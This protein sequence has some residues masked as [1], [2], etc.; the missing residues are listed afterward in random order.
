MEHCQ[1]SRGK[2][3][4]QKKGPTHVR[5]TKEGRKATWWQSTMYSIIKA[6]KKKT[7]TE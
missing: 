6:T 1:T 5:A 3:K 7:Y 4:Q 2:E